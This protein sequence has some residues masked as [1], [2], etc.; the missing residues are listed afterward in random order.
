MP[1]VFFICKMEVMLLV[2]RELVCVLVSQSC[3]T[4]YNPK[5]YNPQ[6]SSVHGILQARILER[7]GLPF[8]SPGDGSS[9]LRDGTQVSCNNR[10]ILYRLTTRS[11]N[12]WVILNIKKTTH[13]QMTINSCPWCIYTFLQCYSAISLFG[14][15]FWAWP[16][17]LLWLKEH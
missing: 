10:Q 1:Q 5:D 12:C 2:L 3:L 7:V 14:V 9:R 8:P 15:Y 13:T 11:Y 6:G 16:Y 4:L 17:D